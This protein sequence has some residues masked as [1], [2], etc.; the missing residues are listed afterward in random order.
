[1]VCCSPLLPPL[2][3]LDDLDHQSLIKISPSLTRFW[4]LF[5]Y[6]GLIFADSCFLLLF[7]RLLDCLIDAGSEYQGKKLKVGFARPSSDAIK[8]SNLYV[9]NLPLSFTSADVQQVFAPYGTIIELNILKGASILPLYLYS[10][11]PI[12]LLLASSSR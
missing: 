7:V 4:S 10:L 2:S 9:A 6:L 3:S 8:H 11:Y 1:M 12:H 5:V